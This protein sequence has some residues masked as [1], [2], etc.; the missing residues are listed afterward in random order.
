MGILAGHICSR[1]ASTKHSPAFAQALSDA[2]SLVAEIGA[3][4]F[5]PYLHEIRAESAALQGR[6]DERLRELREAHRLFSEMGAT[7]HAERVAR[8]LEGL[9]A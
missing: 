6:S 7:G 5:E 2:E 9:P 3:R 1:G 4:A 8:E